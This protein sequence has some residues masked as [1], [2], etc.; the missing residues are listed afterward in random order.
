MMK[1]I[2]EIYLKTPFYGVRRMTWQLQQE[3]HNVNE[4]RVRRL[5]RIMGLEAIYP[6]PRTSQPGAGATIHPYLLRG[7][8]IT[9]PDHVW[10]SD[11][12]YIP[13]E[14]G[15]AF[16][17]VVM[18]WATRYVISWELSTT[19]DALLCIETLDAAL[20]T[21]RKPLIF[22][23][24]QGS[25]FTCHDISRRL[26][27]NDIRISH[28]GK[29]RCIDNVFVERLWRSVKY[30]EVF[31]KTYTDAHDAR[32]QLGAYLKF[33]NHERPHSALDN[34][35]PSAVY[36]KAQQPDEGDQPKGTTPTASPESRGA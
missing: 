14:R 20:A 31:L 28:D 34:Q 6:K 32:K 23:S 18:D 29:G 35:P 2:D 36:F 21:A 11:I 33:Y 26:L 10:A 22:N 15:F 13:L 27:E 1:R 17:C 30:E 4:K 8:P 9:G 16:L 7:L 3:G 25:Q 19:Q 5:M 24:D 12:T